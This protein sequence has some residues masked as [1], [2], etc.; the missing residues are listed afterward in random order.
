MALQSGDALSDDAASI[1]IRPLILGSAA[2]RVRVHFTFP[3]FRFLNKFL[4]NGE[5]T[6]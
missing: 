4:D 1:P 2:T 6:V 3:H 5:L